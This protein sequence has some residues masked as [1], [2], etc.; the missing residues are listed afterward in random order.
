M[1]DRLAKT[2]LQFVT[3]ARNPG[4][5]CHRPRLATQTIVYQVI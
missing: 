3:C 2:L 5:R 4:S 1:L